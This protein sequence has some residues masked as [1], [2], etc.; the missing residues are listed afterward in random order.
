MDI[1]FVFLLVM[2]FLT[3]VAVEGL[4]RTVTVIAT[5]RRSRR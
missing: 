1:S 4:Y 2:G 5:R 3:C